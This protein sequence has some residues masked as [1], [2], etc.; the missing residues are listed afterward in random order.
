MENEKLNV[1]HIEK[2]YKLLSN[3]EFELNLRL[4][5]HIYTDNVLMQIK[6]SI[7]IQ[8]KHLR[9]L[10]VDLELKWVKRILLNGF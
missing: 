8:K 5:G 10:L 9:C 1:K 2:C 7:Q 6:N 3:A 4:T